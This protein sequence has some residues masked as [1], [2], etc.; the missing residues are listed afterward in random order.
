MVECYLCRSDVFYFSSICI[1]GPRTK[2][3]IFLFICV[4]GKE[5]SRKRAVERACTVSIESLIC[6]G[7]FNLVIILIK[8][9]LNKELKQAICFSFNTQLQKKINNFFLCPL[10]HILLRIMRTKEIKE[11]EKR[12]KL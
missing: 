4:L 2:L 6:M 3:Y 5:V 1:K 12:R 9:R 10:I 7:G 11:E 8:T